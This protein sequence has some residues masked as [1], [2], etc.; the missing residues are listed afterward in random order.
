VI[1]WEFTPEDVARIRFAFSPLF[2]LVMS[3]IVLRAPGSHSLH[4]PWVRAT[5]PLVARLDLSELF[6]LVPVHGAT[7]DF[8]APPPASPLPDFTEELEALRATPPGRVATDLA[9]VPGLPEP[10]AARIRGDPAAAT[11]RIAGTLQAYWDIALAGHW[12]RIQALLEADVLWRSRRL[13]TGGALALFEDL[14]ETISWHGG[15][16]T[17]AD[18]WQYAGSLSGEGLLLVPAV[19]TWPGVRKMIEPYQP[20]LAYPARGIGTLWETGAPPPP[21]ALAALIGQTRAA[22]LTA[23]AEPCSTTALARRLQVTPGAVSQHLSVLLDAGM[24]TR[25]RVGRSVLYR[26]TRSGD[27]LAAASR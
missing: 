15:R 11:S 20:M 3:L 7:A 12:P 16:L 5:R 8:L 23:L 22:M 14:D 21:H 17:A 9:E 13:A 4:L 6:A 26:R 24:V 27:T 25:S 10:V 2:E 1:E 19:M 18:P